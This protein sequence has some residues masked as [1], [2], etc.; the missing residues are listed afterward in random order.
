M[1][2]RRLVMAVGGSILLTGCSV[3]NEPK[4]TPTPAPPTA[5]PAPTAPSPLPT[6]ITLKYQTSPVD[7]PGGSPSDPFRIV[8][9]DPGTYPIVGGPN[10]TDMNT[11]IWWQIEYWNSFTGEDTEGWVQESGTTLNF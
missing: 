8:I 2:R 5:E 6:S 7:Y 4:A 10:L 9:L 1:N 3:S 11:R